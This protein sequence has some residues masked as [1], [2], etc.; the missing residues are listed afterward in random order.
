MLLGHVYNDKDEE[1]RRV[2]SGCDTLDEVRNF[3]LINIFYYNYMNRMVKHGILWILLG[4]GHGYTLFIMIEI[5]VPILDLV[6][7]MLC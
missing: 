1:L 3:I 6:E 5:Y 7:M 4:Y 2:M